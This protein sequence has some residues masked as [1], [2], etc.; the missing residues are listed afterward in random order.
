MTWTTAK[1]TVPGWYWWR[2]NPGDEEIV[3]VGEVEVYLSSGDRLKLD[4]A[5][6]EWAGPLDP[7]G[8]EG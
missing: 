6:G 8:Q 7:P 2:V 5:G 4:T 1:P 3:E